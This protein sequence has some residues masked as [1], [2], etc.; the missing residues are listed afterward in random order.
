MLRNNG[1]VDVE[2]SPFVVY[3]AGGFGMDGSVTT[4][5]SAATT[6]STGNV[7]VLPMEI[8]GYVRPQPQ[9]GVPTAIATAFGTVDTGSTI[10]GP[11]PVA[12]HA[13][14]CGSNK[15]CNVVVPD[16]V[17]SR[18]NDMVEGGI[19]GRFDGVI[20]QGA[21]VER[22]WYRVDD[23][24]P[25]NVDRNCAPCEYSWEDI[26]AIRI[27]CESRGGELEVTRDVWNGCLVPGE[28]VQMECP[29]GWVPCGDESCA[30][31]ETV[32]QDGNCCR[33]VLI[34]DDGDDGGIDDGGTD[35][36]TFDGGGGGGY[37][38]GGGGGYDTGGGG[39]DGLTEELPPPS[40]NPLQVVVDTEE[41]P[42]CAWDPMKIAGIAVIGLIGVG[43]LTKVMKK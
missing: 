18:I 42:V 14:F 16:A 26:E 34:E 27:D 7:T 30:S 3:H 41:G 10:E 25:V 37:D 20:V 24:Y 19:P 29:P 43:L 32:E 31:G 2:Y 39:D 35:G 17:A 23:I 13:L 12:G 6:S 4:G 9:R 38:T 11:P 5:G 1:K 15:L 33:C 36:G 40:C 22:T 8:V 28:C 21:D